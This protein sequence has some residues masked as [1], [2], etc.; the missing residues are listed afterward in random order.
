MPGGD[1][2]NKRI[3]KIILLNL[4]IAVVNVIL[5]SK[6]LVGLTFTG[7]ALTTALAATVITMSVLAFGYGNYTLLFKEPK[8]QPIKLFKNTELTSSTDY[9]SALE[10]LKTKVVFRGDIENALEQIDRME[11]K[12][13]ALDTILAQFFTPQEITYTRFQSAIDSV[14]TLF[15]HNVKKMINRMVIFDQKDFEKVSLRMTRAY[16][17]QEDSSTLKATR[18]QYEIYKEHLNYIRS[19]VEMNENILTKLDGLLLE[20]SKLDDINEE[21]LENMAAIQ[22]I[23]NLIAQTRYY[24]V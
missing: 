15:Y 18:A 16:Q 9:R 21:D 14:K 17:N 5:F 7:G 13:H 3:W 11:D 22:E 23:N 6:G 12:D 4:V 24:K 2:V 10:G 19:L 20:V 8:T 1:G